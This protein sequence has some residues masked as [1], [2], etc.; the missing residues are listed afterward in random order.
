[1]KVTA[2]TSSD[3]RGG[4]GTLGYKVLMANIDFQVTRTYSQIGDKT[5]GMSFGRA[6]T[7]GSLRWENTV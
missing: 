7:L 2:A 3:R 6:S 4:L 1:M 5:L